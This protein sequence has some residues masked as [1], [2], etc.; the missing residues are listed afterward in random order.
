[1][2]CFPPFTTEVSLRGRYLEGGFVVHLERH[3]AR[4]K[5][6]LGGRIVQTAGDVLIR[7]S[8]ELGVRPQ[9][10]ALEL[11]GAVRLLDLHAGGVVAVCHDHDASVGAKV[12]IPELMTGGKRSDEQ[13]RRIPSRRVAAKH[14][15]RRAS[16]GR[17]ALRADLMRTR[18]GA[19]RRRASALIADPIETNRIGVTL[20][21]NGL[22]RPAAIGEDSS[23]RISVGVSSRSLQ[24]TKLL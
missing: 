23:G 18:I 2:N 11:A 9:R 21:C 22:L 14:R 6:F 24:S 4:D 13:L 5:A 3:R 15:V 7:A 19:V 10:D 12:Q 16:D 8:R 20:V 17:F 1:M